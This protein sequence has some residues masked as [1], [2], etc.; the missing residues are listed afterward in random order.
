M[1]KAALEAF[2]DFFR[3]F[4]RE[5]KVNDSKYFDEVWDSR[6]ASAKKELGK[7]TDAIKTLKEV[8][9]AIGGKGCGVMTEGGLFWHYCSDSNLHS[10][11]MSFT[12]TLSRR[13]GIVGDPGDVH[14]IIPPQNSIGYAVYT[15][16]ELVCE[17]I[18]GLY[19][20]FRILRK[21]NK[22]IAVL[23]L[24]MLRHESYRGMHVI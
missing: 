4:G 3:D 22:I 5:V 21:R 18:E 13:E 1:L 7:A 20:G 2:L 11:I 16:N 23:P 14:H 12:E 9:S 15:D 19:K 6:K 8:E 24:V 17:E 10:N